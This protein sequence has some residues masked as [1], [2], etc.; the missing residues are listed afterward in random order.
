MVLVAAASLGLFLVLYFLLI[1]VTAVSE[2]I[3]SVTARVTG[4]ALAGVGAGVTVK[5]PVLQMGSLQFVVIPDCTPLGPIMLLTGA[6]LAFPAPVGSKLIGILLGALL[7]SSLNLLR[8][9]NLVY[10][11]RLAPQW[12]DMAHLVIWQSVMILAGIVFWMVW[13]SWVGKTSRAAS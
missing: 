9:I 1:R 7:L 2:A 8:V 4:V 3:T 10:V 5:G 11:A 6:I 12:L 13:I